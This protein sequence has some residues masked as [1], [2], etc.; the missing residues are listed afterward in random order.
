MITTVFCYCKGALSCYSQEVR[1]ITRQLTEG[2]GF[3]VVPRDVMSRRSDSTVIA[4]NT[5]GAVDNDHLAS[6]CSEVSCAVA[7]AVDGGVPSSSSVSSTIFILL[8]TFKA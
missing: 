3:P 2:L 4:F 6:I 8:L 5:Y 7:V 1:V